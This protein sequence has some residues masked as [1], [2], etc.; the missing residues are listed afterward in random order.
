MKRII[1]LIALLSLFATGLQAQIIDATNNSPHKKEKTS[2]NSSLYK[3]T[4]HYLRWEMGYSQLLALAYGCQINPFIMVGGGVGV[5]INEEIPL[6]AEILISTPNNKWSFIGDIKIGYS[7]GYDS[8]MNTNYYI[9]P[10]AGI[11]YKDIGLTLGIHTGY[12]PYRFGGEA[13]ALPTISVYYNLP[14]KI[15]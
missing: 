2:S 10:S 1:T 11:Q 5:S 13:D 3:P 14:L 15:H 8:Y 9:A 7:Y 4:G 12:Y 6:Y